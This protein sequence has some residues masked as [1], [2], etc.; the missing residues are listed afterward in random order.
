[1]RTWV[2]CDDFYHP[3]S[4]VIKGL[5]P[6]Q[7]LGYEFEFSLDAADWSANKLAQF[8]VL[9]ISKSNRISAAQ[10]GTWISE[11]VE[12]ALTAYVE[13]GGGLLIIHSG[14]VD[15]AESA[16]IMDLIGGVFTHHPE[17]CLVTMELVAEHPI[18]AGLTQLEP[19]TLKD[20][21]YFMKMTDDTQRKLFLTST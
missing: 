14:T 11:E 12:Q 7:Q 4:T 5:E 19:F 2:M 3:A 6:L 20:E 13:Q 10:E 15:Y 8:P 16:S 17:Q 1:M 9:A 21:H 18:T